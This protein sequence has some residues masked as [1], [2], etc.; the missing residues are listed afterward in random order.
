MAETAVPTG[1][2]RQERKPKFRGMSE[3]AEAAEREAAEGHREDA[4]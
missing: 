4:V 1:G 2:R 3:T